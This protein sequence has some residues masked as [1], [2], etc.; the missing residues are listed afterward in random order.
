MMADT[1]YAWSPIRAGGETDIVVDP[2]GRERRVVKSRNTIDVGEEVT[3][4]DLGVSEEEFQQYI[5]SGAVR[6]YPY[7]DNVPDDEPPTEFLRR[8]IREQAETQ[9]SEEQQLLQAAGMGA[10]ISDADLV[11][12][13]P[14]TSAS[15]VQT[16]ADKTAKEPA[17]ATSGTTAKK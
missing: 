10:V 7:P 4:D 6:P 17:T 1:M 8:M 14:E 15:A 2:L 13:Q 12:L 5:D 11:E 3:P 9:I 16:A